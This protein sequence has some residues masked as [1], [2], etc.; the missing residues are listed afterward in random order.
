MNDLTI[1]EYQGQRVLTTKQ[2]AETYN[3]TE[4]TLHDNYR[5]NKKRYNEGIS[6]FKLEGYD[7]D[8]FK[9]DPENFGLVPKNAR[10]FYL[11]TEKGCF[12]HAKSLGTDKAWDVFESL[13]DHYFRTRE[14]PQLFGRQLQ[15]CINQISAIKEE[16]EQLKQLSRPVQ[17]LLPTFDEKP[18]ETV[19]GHPR[20]RNRVRIY[21]AI[22]RLPDKLQ[23]QVNQMIDNKVTYVRISQFL[24]DRGHSISKSAVCNYA[25]KRI[26]HQRRLHCIREQT[27]AL[28]PTN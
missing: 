18:S 17:I 28:V 11:W 1:I 22:D 19:D 26:E 8:R 20:Q 13:V 12:L 16:V 2:L 3:T 10:I 7:L 5:T 25:K 14:L 9:N 23:A 15:E 21:C 6:H 4:K 24:K 27:L